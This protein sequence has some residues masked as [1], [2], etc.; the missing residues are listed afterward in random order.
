MNYN[1]FRKTVVKAEGKHNFRVTNS[2]GTKEAWRWIK[3]NKWLNIGQPI[4]ERE[5]GL[6]VKAINSTLQDQILQGKDANLPC[7]MGRLEIRKFESNVKLIDGKLVTNL[8]VNWEKTLHL[9]HEDEEAYKKR[10]LVRYEGRERFTIYYNK[11]PA[12]YTNKTFYQFIPTRRFKK[13]LKHK[14][15]NEGLD[16]LLLG[17][18]N[19]LYQYKTYNGQNH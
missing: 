6:I 14:I 13:R 2:N 11:A 19:E 15:L 5:L 12:L 1:D 7:R 3:K 18:K 9:W 10:L 8:P 16:A 17:K 4:T